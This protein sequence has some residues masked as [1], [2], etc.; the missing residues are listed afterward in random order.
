MMLW[1]MSAHM[2]SPHCVLMALDIAAC[3]SAA[4]LGGFHGPQGP[5]S[6]PCPPWNWGLAGVG[7][8]WVEGCWLLHLGP[9][10]SHESVT[11]EKLR[12]W[13]PRAPCAGGRA[14]T[15]ASPPSRDRRTDVSAHQRNQ[16]QQCVLG[17]PHLNGKTHRC[18]G[19]GGGRQG[20]KPE[21][22]RWE[23]NPPGGWGVAQE[24]RRGEGQQVLQRACRGCARCRGD[25]DGGYVGARA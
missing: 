19:Q 22:T 6:P 8:A 16:G 15:A 7:K 14:G 3:G 20:T 25:E 9:N 1:L 13:L 10:P 11:G 5:P 18:Q 21:D 4:F 17:G 23:R 24:S 2:R 12:S